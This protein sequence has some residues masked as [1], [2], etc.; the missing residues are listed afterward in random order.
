MASLAA[1]QDA[2]AD[3]IKSAV[4]GEFGPSKRARQAEAPEAPGGSGGSGGSPRAL[5]KNVR[6]SKYMANLRAHAQAAREAR[7]QVAVL[8]QERDEARR[9]RDVALARVK[10]LDAVVVLTDAAPADP[11]AQVTSSL[12]QARVA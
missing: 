8:T 6:Q 7:A 10:E 5:A 1:I 3:A 4:A 12:Q 11:V 9:E 2:V